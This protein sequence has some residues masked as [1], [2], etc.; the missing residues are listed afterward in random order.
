MSNSGSL[1]FVSRVHFI[2]GK[3]CR[4]YW[5]ADATKAKFFPEP[6][7]REIYLKTKRGRLL[8]FHSHRVFILGDNSLQ[9]VRK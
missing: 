1:R 4:I 9:E 3:P 6:V 2:E 8:E 5:S 7:A